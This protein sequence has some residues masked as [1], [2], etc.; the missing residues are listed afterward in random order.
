MFFPSRN[1]SDQAGAT[2]VEVMVSAL[3]MI[4]IAISVFAALEST[5]RAG[6]QERHR[7]RAY[8][9]GQDDQAR[10][11]SLK[12]SVLTRLNE[13]R[14][15]RPGRDHLHDHLNG[16]P[17]DRP[18][19]HRRLRLGQQLR[20]LRRDLL[21]GDV[22][23]HR[24]AAARGHREPGRPAQRHTRLQPRRARRLGRRQP[25]Q[26][27]LGDHDHGFRGKQLQR[28]HEATGCALFG[29][30]P[31]GNY[32]VTAATANVVDADGL[33]PAAT[34]TSVVA[35]SSNTLS[36]QYDTPSGFT[37]GFKRISTGTT[38]TPMDY[39]RIR[40]FNTGMTQ[41]RSFGT[42]GT[43]APTVKATG[44]FP[45][46]SPYAVYAG[47]CDANTPPT[48]T[49]VGSAPLYNYTVPVGQSAP[50]PANFSLQ[51]PSL[52]LTAYQGNK[53]SGTGSSGAVVKVTDT[54]C[55]AAGT[56]VFTTTSVGKISE[57]ATPSTA[58]FPG[59]PYGEYD[60]CVS[61]ISTSGKRMVTFDSVDL[62]SAS[63]PAVVA[64]PLRNGATG[65][66]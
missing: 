63:V 2:L 51:L 66:C 45:F 19:G 29:D 50:T 17:E 22:V 10:L 36:L 8:S 1:F 65:T 14:S 58:A 12:I 56:R 33:P 40:V 49:P 37:V 54:N 4:T 55:P 26:P 21:E 15:R 25:Q 60:I 57:V 44:L 23:E 59:L 32:N 16:R 46:T 27:I 53:A 6:A 11:R 64:A 24:L 38:V 41:T 30:L 47:A 3:L 35:G 42:A 9:I 61:G 18:H 39:D 43:Y 5:G 20:R 62:F 31:V 52:N 34:P 13:T 48:S 28:H 7:A